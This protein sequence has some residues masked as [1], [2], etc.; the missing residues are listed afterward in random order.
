MQFTQLGGFF[1]A[2]I[3]TMQNWND[4]SLARMPGI[5]DRVVRLRLDPDEGGMNLNMEPDLIDR[6]AER[7]ERASDKLVERFV[8]ATPDG[9]QAKGWDEHRFVRLNTLLK[10]IN[11]QAPGV[12]NALSP[13]CPHATDLESLLSFYS[14]SGNAGDMQ[15]LPPGF[16]EPLS[17]ELHDTLIKA[18][19]ALA[20][21]SEEIQKTDSLQ[22]TPV[23][24]PVL[25]VR[26]PL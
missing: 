20:S 21:L 22:F 8:A 1:A 25:R 15:R 2:I 24:S 6:I 9:P 7:G 16:E 17:P 19:E 18:V 10:M 23:P 26:P 12:A 5:R 11:A 13:N 3:K 4:N 14:E